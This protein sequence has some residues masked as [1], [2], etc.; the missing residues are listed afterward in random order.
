MKYEDRYESMLI[1]C[2]FYGENEELAESMMNE[3]HSE[4]ASTIP[5]EE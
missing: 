3:C 1:S 4:N 2:T 5:L